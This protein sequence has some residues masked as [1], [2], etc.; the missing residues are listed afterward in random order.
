MVTTALEQTAATAS[1][2]MNSPELSNCSRMVRFDNE[3][4]LIPKTSPTRSKM[5][6]VLTKSYALP[7]WKRKTQQ[8]SVSEVEDAAGSS[9]QLQCPEDNRV[10][11]K[12]PI[13]TFVPI[14]F[15]L[16]C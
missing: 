2:M 10:T 1:F 6:V 13:P 12:V 15:G 4:V 3:C 11:I 5:P 14:Q 9:A 16:F 8:L 7:L